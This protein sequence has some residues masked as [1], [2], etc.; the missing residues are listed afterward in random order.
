[1]DH[2]RNFVPSLAY[3]ISPGWQTR[4][5]V[6]DGTMSS[7]L[8]IRTGLL[9]LIDIHLVQLK[10]PAVVWKGQTV[11]VTLVWKGKN[12]TDFQGLL[13]ELSQLVRFGQWSWV[14][15]QMRIP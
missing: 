7:F 3:G 10:F 9:D 14:G 6:S 15:E 8:G 4:F 1:M 2:R 11:S 12:E 5:V 13:G